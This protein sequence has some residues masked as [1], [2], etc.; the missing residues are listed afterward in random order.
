[1]SKEV[2][3]AIDA[4]KEIEEQLLKNDPYQIVKVVSYSRE[5]L[6]EYYTIGRNQAKKSFRYSLIAMWLGFIVLLLGVTNAIMPVY[7][8]Y[9]QF[10]EVRGEKVTAERNQDTLTK[11]QELLAKGQEKIEG[12]AS[13]KNKAKEDDKNNTEKKTQVIEATLSEANDIVLLTGAVIEFIAAV[14]L[15]VYRYSIRQLTLFYSRQLKFHNVLLAHRLTANME[16]KKEETLM[17]I[18]DKMFEEK[19]QPELETP[20]GKGKG[21]IGLLKGGG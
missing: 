16:E 19:D 15:W 7:Q 5:T 9:Q 11:Q 17:K 21:L 14:F 10:E 12:E 2:G 6:R 8:I 13:E 4:Q 3:A 20:S 1:L 18:I